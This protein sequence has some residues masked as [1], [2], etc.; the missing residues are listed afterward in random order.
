MNVFPPGLLR[1]LPSRQAVVQEREKLLRE[2]DNGVLLGPKVMSIG[3]LENQL[4]QDAVVGPSVL[5]DQGRRMVLEKLV[6]DDIHGLI[7]KRLAWS[8]NN[9]L[10]QRISELVEEARL[11]GISPERLL[12]LAQGHIPLERAQAIVNIQRRYESFLAEKN[13]IDRAGQRRQL[14]TALKDGIQPSLLEN[15]SLIEFR[16]FDRLTPWQTELIMALGGIAPRVRLHLCRP[17]WIL[18]NPPDDSFDRAGPFRE[19]LRLIAKF[20]SMGQDSRGLELLFD[21]PGI[22][23]QGDLV[24][25]AE[26]LFDPDFDNQDVESQG[27][28]RILAC[29]G[30]Y[31]EVEEVGR[32]IRDLIQDGAAPENIA[33]GVSDMGLYGDML[34]D[35]FRRFRLPLFM[36]RGAPLKIQAPVRAI[37]SL[38]RL[39]ISNFEREL[40]LDLLASPYLDFDLPFSWARAAE[41]TAK[42]GVTDDRAGGGYREN[43]FR[44]AQRSPA[45]RADAETLIQKLDTIREM[46]RPLSKPQTWPNFDRNIRMILEKLKLE[47]QI[48]ESPPTWLKRD[49]AS[50]SRLWE[51]LDQ[52][53]KAAEQTGMLEPLPPDRLLWGFRHAI[54]ETNVGERGHGAGGIRVMSLFDLHGLRYDYFFMVGLGEGGFPKPRPEGILVEDQALE[55]I[56]QATRARVFT[57]SAVRYRQ[58]EQVFFHA[59]TAAR[60]GA[61]CTYTC[62]DEHGRLMLASPIVDEITRLFPDNS[63]NV[64]FPESGSAVRYDRVLTRPELFG[65]LAWDALAH[66]QQNSTVE[67]ALKAIEDYPEVLERWQSIKSRH[68]I[69]RD[70]RDGVF[71]GSIGPEPLMPYF[72]SLRRYKG[73]VLVSP[74]FFEEFGA[75]AFAFWAK[76]IIGLAEPEA[77]SDEV[78]PLS[79]GAILHAILHRFLTQARDEGLLPLEPNER[80]VDLLNKI[81]QEEMELA[82]KRLALGRKPLWEAKQKDIFRTLFRWLEFETKRTDGLIPQWF[83]WSFGPEDEGHKVPP[84][85]FR[86]M[87]GRQ[88]YF[89]GRADRIDVSEKEAWVLDYKDS[90]NDTTY[91]KMLKPE[92]LGVQ[93]FQPPVYQLA[94]ARHLSKQTKAGYIL[95]RKLSPQPVLSPG[96]EDNLFGESPDLRREMAEKGEPNFLNHLDV[97]WSNLTQGLFATNPKDDQACQ[98]CDFRIACRRNAETEVE[99]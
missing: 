63:L 25:A 51:C 65:K 39:A 33:V 3:R 64:E 15:I 52:M 32:I 68:D 31:H 94:A 81:S 18:D 57:T 74:T 59:L 42:A 84:L 10:V 86:M 67:A 80:T 69:E 90:K 34:E 70:G 62:S 97:T 71:A 28:I 83:E 54:E 56:N 24:V 11:G 91:K 7:P 78:H 4:I 55:K 45:D 46:L 58:E 96:T 98:Y 20:E 88:V 76:R 8:N 17:R 13:L 44:L 36:R 72:A 26:H 85:D 93:S 49:L 75:C 77:P 21:D 60:K 12:E 73:D 16:D 66:K 19:T 9:G 87:D 92:A 43:L 37:T 40:I 5:S 48:H 41:L 30:R 2:S 6:V 23:S 82:E 47:S 14:V 61:V 50:L 99:E 53:A 79:R 95:L 35:V 27:Q 1:V 89:Q 29:T 22:E 38:M